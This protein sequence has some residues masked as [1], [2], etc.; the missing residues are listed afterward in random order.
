MEGLR[1]TD[2]GQRVLVRLEGELT[3]DVTGNIKK[4]VET[5]LQGMDRSVVGVDLAGVSILDSSGIGLLVSLNSTVMGLGRSM[6]LYAVPDRVRKTLA[7]VQLE[8]FFSIVDGEGDLP[9]A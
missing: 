2:T 3:K 5:A 9:E 8:S 7:L 1:I 4:E 6:I